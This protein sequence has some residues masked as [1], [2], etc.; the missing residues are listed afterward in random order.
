[1]TLGHIAE[2]KSITINDRLV[3]YEARVERPVFFVPGLAVVSY[4]VEV[5]ADGKKLDHK[6]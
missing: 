2:V 6:E 3:A 4:T 5:A 1:V